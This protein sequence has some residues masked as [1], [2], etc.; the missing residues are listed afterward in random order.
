MGP[1]LE[2]RVQSFLGMD[3]S[4]ERSNL[5]FQNQCLRKNSGNRREPIR[6]EPDL[7][8]PAIPTSGSEPSP[9]SKLSRFLLF[10]VIPRRIENVT[11][12]VQVRSGTPFTGRV[13]K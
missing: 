2:R 13:V 5:S 1:F 12:G 6:Q 7:V 11:M 9:D 10:N 3:L 8:Q 4:C